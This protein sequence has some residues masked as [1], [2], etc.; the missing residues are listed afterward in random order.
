MPSL[1]R[2]RPRRAVSPTR[3]DLAPREV[4]THELNSDGLT[5]IHLDS[6]THEEVGALAARFGWHPLDVETCSCGA[7]GRR[8]PSTPRQRAAPTSSPSSTYRFTTPTSAG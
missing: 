2:I 7:S 1:P 4:R 6:P 3:G 8:S 5:W